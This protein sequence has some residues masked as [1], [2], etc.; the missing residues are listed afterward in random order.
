MKVTLVSG[1]GGGALNYA[2]ELEARGVLSKFITTLPTVLKRKIPRSK[3]VLNI[4]PEVIARLPQ[5]LPGLRSWFPSEY[6]KA[7]TFGHW[8]K[9][10]LDAAED[11]VLAFSNYGLEVHATARA[12]GA[13]TVLARGSSH[14]LTQRRLVERD[15]EQW[16]WSDRRLFHERLIARQL[17]EYDQADYVFVESQFSERT[18]LAEGFPPR[19][20][21]RAAAGV[22]IE[23]FRPLGKNDQTFRVVC[24]GDGLRKGVVYLLE[25]LKQL[26]L[27]NSEF[28]WIGVGG[29][30]GNPFMEDYAGQFRPVSKVPNEELPRH[31]SQASVVV[32]PSVEDGW[33]IVVGEAL[34]C[35]VPVICTS[36]TGASEIIQDGR[37]GFVVPARDVEGLKT[38]LKYLHA[39]ETERAAMGLAARERAEQYT[40][41]RFGHA[42]KTELERVLRDRNAGDARRASR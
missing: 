37:E 23:R 17:R 24:V 9:R 26:A 36:N 10:R 6:L 12:R 1:F 4:V 22:D 11:I 21:L 18:F 2:E 29:A 31:Y 15:F 35:G 41:T 38:R 27:P 19:K 13:I 30:A 33:C 34:A 7:V 20:L 28:V 25:A 39:H 16:N 3:I 40:W 42:L 14:I 5:R 32:V 8:A